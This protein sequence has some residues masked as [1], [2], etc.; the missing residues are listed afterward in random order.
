[1]KI[2][3][4]LLKKFFG[5]NVLLIFYYFLEFFFKIIGFIGFK[6]KIDEVCKNFRVYYSKGLEDEDGDYIVS[7]YCVSNVLGYNLIF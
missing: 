1:M 5:R 4:I 2:N 6:E 3:K 7:I